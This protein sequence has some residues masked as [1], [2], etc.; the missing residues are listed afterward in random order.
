MQYKPLVHAFLGLGL[1]VGLVACAQEAAE[2]AATQEAATATYESADPLAEVRG[3]YEEHYNSGN[4]MAVAGLYTADGVYMPASGSYSVGGD[5]ITGVLESS[6]AGSPTVKI[7]AT[8]TNMYG[9][10]AFER[11][12]YSVEMTPEGA[13][14]IGFSGHYITFSKKQADGSWK[15]HWVL[16]NYDMEPSAEIAAS[17][18]QGLAAV[19]A[20]GDA[21]L[22]ALR[23]EWQ[24]AYNQADGAGTAAMHT[25]NGAAMF[26]GI[27]AM[28]GRAAFAAFLEEAF[29][30]SPQTE[31]TQVDT[32]IIGDWAVARG[33]YAQQLTPPEGEPMSQSGYWITVS[34]KGEDGAW[35]LHWLISNAVAPMM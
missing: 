29:M 26:S 25:E 15:L 14:P 33:T 19:A 20:G 6:L 13:E 1:A 18:T 16:S 31:I 21:A 34:H 3:S 17:M 9:D 28:E 8:E 32:E 27:P 35:K 2:E 5:A 22:D 24:S 7:T 11:G 4:V 10:V 30:A 12:N 23:E